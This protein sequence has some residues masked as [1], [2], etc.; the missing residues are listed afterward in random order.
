MKP[1]LFF[2][3]LFQAELAGEATVVKQML[4]NEN[5]AAALLLRDEW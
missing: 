2:N 3:S 4:R 1:V 5:A